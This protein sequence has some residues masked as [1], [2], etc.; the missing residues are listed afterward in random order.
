MQSTFSR[1]GSASAVAIAHAGVRDKHVDAA[2]LDL[3]LIN[4]SD[5]RDFVANVEC[6]GNAVNLFRDLAR[7]FGL[8]IRDDDFRTVSSKAATKRTPDTVA[9]TGYYSDFD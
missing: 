6:F 2:A 7:G 9:T 5:D 3:D 4:K 8:N 1:N